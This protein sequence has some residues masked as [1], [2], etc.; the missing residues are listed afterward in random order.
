MSVV[1]RSLCAVDGSLYIPTGKA[2]LMH[3]I[4]EAKMGPLSLK[5]SLHTAAD[6]CRGRVL[7]VD[8]MAVLQSMKKTPAMRKLADLKESYVRRTETMLAGF[9]ECRIVIGR[10]ID[11]CLKTKTRQKTAVTS[12]EF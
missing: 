2:S 12:T 10:Y 7:V 1:S 8:A 5:W 11:Q 6:D 9:S 4:E 3:A